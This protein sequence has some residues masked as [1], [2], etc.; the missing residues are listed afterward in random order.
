[1]LQVDKNLGE[2]TVRL[3]TEHMLELITRLVDS[4]N[5][6]LINAILIQL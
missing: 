2:D 5:I 4:Y 1:M 6:V 3:T